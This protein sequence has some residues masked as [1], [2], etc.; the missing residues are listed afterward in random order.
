MNKSTS[1]LFQKV[2]ITKY[3]SLKKL[4]TQLKK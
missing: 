4:Q 1:K 3:N 2:Y